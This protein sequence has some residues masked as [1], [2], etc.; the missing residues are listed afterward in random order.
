MYF[1]NLSKDQFDIMCEKLVSGL[2]V[3]LISV[4]E[5]NNSEMEGQ[6][7]DSLLKMASNALNEL[8][9]YVF[10]TL[11]HYEAVNYHYS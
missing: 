2:A 5:E 6:K 10:I 4:I 11:R 3:R 1:A 8:K 7:D 9:K